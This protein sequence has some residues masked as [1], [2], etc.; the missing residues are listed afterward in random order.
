MDD[1]APAIEDVLNNRAVQERLARYR[2][3]F[4]YDQAYKLDG[5]AS[6]RVAELIESVVKEKRII[7]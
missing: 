7:Q 4:V 1:I 3:K 5:K 2:K 6:R